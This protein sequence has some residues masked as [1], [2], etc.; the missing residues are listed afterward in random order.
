MKNELFETTP[1]PKAY[2]TLAFPV[3]LSMMVSL[4][5]N[6]VDTYCIALTGKQDLVAG[7]SLAAPVFTLMIAFGDIF[8]LGES[9]IISRLLGE[10]N[11]TAAKKA[12]AFCIW[13]SIGFGLL[14]TLIHPGNPHFQDH[15]AGYFY[16]RHS[17]F[18]HQ[19]DA[20][21][22]GH[23]DQPF[24]AAY[25]TDKITAMGIALKSNMITAL[26]LVGFAFGGQPVGNA[27]GAF[28]LS[29]CRQGVLYAAF[30]FL[31][32]NLFGYHGVLLS[33]ACADLATAV[34]EVCIIRNLFK[35]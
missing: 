30:L 16:D 25:G 23:D 4:I 12:S 34:M 2:L 8:G 22:H 19:P 33:Q 11:E 20:E 24:P 9:S 14:V 10:K 18:H 3:V 5:Y 29:V 28:L 6:M 15:D 17:C 35:K 31:L 21:L 13:T 7:V 32:S 1:V 27:L 26:I